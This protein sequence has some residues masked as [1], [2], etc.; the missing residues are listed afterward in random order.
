M[1]VFCAVYEC[2]NRPNR[3]NTRSFHRVRK[4]VVHKGKVKKLR[5]K[6]R[7]KVACKPA[8]AVDRSRSDNAR[9]CKWLI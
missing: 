5:E 8:S 6:R 4:C 9:V 7:E 1:P 2:L 3:E